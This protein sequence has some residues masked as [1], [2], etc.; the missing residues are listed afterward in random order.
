MVDGQEEPTN[1][2]LRSAAPPAD[3][4]GQ[5][6]TP[7]IPRPR[8]PWL[9][10][11]RDEQD[12]P[13]APATTP[14]PAEPT[15]VS[16]TPAESTPVTPTP[17]EPT[18][19]SPT[20][21]ESTPVTPTP[22][23]PTPS[24]DKTDD[25]ATGDTDAKAVEETGGKAAP[26]VGETAP[27][28]APTRVGNPRRRVPFAHALRTPPRRMAGAAA[29][30]TREWS[31]RPSG[32]LAVPGLFLLGLVAAMAATGALLVPAAARNAQP[33]AAGAVGSPTDA[34]WPQTESQVPLPP[35]ATAVPGVPGEVPSGLPGASG[36]PSGVLPSGG[37]APVVARPVDALAG[38]AQTT[39]ARVEIS[40]VAMQAYGYAELVLAQ[41]EPGCQLSWT[42]LAAIG[43][44]ESRHGQANGATLKPNGRAEDPLI[45]GLPLDGQGGR[46]LIR[47]TDQGRLDNDTTFDRAV[48]P[49]QF[50]PTTWEEIGADADGDGVKDPHNLN[51]AALAAGRYLCKGGRNLTVASDWWQA[52]LSYN[53]VR[54]YAQDV[55]DTANRYG[56][57]SRA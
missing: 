53:D 48:G 14:T 19:V 45:F 40:P 12:A 43:Y 25:K 1:R 31:R 18:P 5:G 29:R 8:R 36:A 47:D 26:A 7:R 21:A 17:A 51:D 39:G 13:P 52:I 20:P 49:M 35:G 22:A 56:Q 41:T 9:A 24:T 37:A 57:A 34:A 23:E 3:P 46:M 50:I 30:A 10:R 6:G 54:R 2:Q 28:A 33:T 11:W 38:W 15:P 4:T 55:F 32:R 16:P 42:T 44:V 27:V